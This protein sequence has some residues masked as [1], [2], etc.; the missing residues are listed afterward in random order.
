[1]LGIAHA[2]APL[3]ALYIIMGLLPWRLLVQAALNCAQDH[4]PIAMMQLGDLGSPLQMFGGSAG[5]GPY[6]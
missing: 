2:A 1:M 3:D 5:T 4:P 6:I